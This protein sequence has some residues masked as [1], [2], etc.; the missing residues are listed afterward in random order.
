[1]V[2]FDKTFVARTRQL[3]S[4]GKVRSQLVLTRFPEGWK[5]VSVADKSVYWTR[6]R[7]IAP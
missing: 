7:P 2:E 6:K 5:I 1:M 3:L 4:E